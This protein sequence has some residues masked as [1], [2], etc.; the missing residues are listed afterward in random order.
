MDGEG[1]GVNIGH[2]AHIVPGIL[3]V[4][5]LDVPREVFKD[6]TVH[7]WAGPPAGPQYLVQGVK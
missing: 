1:W 2:P 4:L 7:G 5:D 3:A 6:E